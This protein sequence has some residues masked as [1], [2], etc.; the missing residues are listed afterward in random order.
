MSWWCRLKIHIAKDMARRGCHL[1]MPPAIISH[2]CLLL[3]MTRVP[4]GVPGAGGVGF[5]GLQG[6]TAGAQPGRCLRAERRLWRGRPHRGC[7]R[8][9]LAIFAR[10]QN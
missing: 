8:Q 1:L 10:L 7:Q 6:L 9:V 4:S 3:L 2:A 5:P